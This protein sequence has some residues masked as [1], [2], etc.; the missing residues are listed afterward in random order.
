MEMLSA[1]EHS[2]DGV[3]AVDADDRIVFWNSSAERMLGYTPEEAIG[4]PCYELLAG[5]GAGEGIC[6][7]H[8]SVMRCAIRGGYPESYDVV[9]RSRSGELRLLNIS[10]VVLRGRGRRSTL[11]VHVFRDVTDKRE[12]EGRARV[13][14][15]SIG[16][17]S[18]EHPDLTKRE[19]EVL[20]MLACGFNN[21]QIA[22]VL[23]ISP[24]TVRNHIEHLLGKMGVH[25]KLEAVVQGARLRLF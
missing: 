10:I 13:L 9:Q 6:S 4:R 1:F 8:C 19:R 24:T 11:G 3:Y 2:A 7:P 5:E 12:I 17:G 25:S 21:R 14:L 20:R 18:D 16:A 15:G 23:G 22:A